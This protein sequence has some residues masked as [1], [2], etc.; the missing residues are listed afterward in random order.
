LKDPRHVSSLEGKTKLNAQ[1]SETHV[2]D[3][4]KRERLRLV[5]LLVHDFIFQRSRLSDSIE[6]KSTNPKV[7]AF[8]EINTQEL[9]GQG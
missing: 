6:K 9:Y 4:P 5:R 1:E 7:G 3:L 2:P 8:K